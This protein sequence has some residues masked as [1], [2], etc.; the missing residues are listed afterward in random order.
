MNANKPK[1][2]SYAYGDDHQKDMLNFFYKSKEPCEA[3]HSYQRVVLAERLV[4]KYVQ[5]SSRSI[6]EIQVV[7]VGCSV[8]QFAIHFA[9]KGF[10]AIGLDFDDSA[11]KIANELK[12]SEG[13]QALFINADVSDPS[14]PLPPIDIAIC[15]DIFEHLHDDELGSLLVGLKHKL[16]KE[17]CVV[18]HTQPLEYDYLFW[19]RKLGIIEC[20][21]LLRPFMHLPKRYFTKIVRA[22]AIFIDL[23]MMLILNKTYKEHIK[24]FGHCNPLTLV[25]LLDIFNR[26]GYDVD[27]IESGFIS[28]QFK[29]NKANLFKSQPITHRSLWGI[30]T[31]KK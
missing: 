14:V 3:N 5:K 25:R 2:T 11:I 16:N 23:G 18:F 21:I 27:L 8:G 19:N 28:P 17:G 22:Y 9:K 6:Q 15:F 30:A 20:P 31:A 13:S 29:K 10:K 4:E 26:A 24:R 1:S 12:V 7:D